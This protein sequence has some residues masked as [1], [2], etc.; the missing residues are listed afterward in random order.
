MAAH[1]Q[2]CSLARRKASRHSPPQ[3]LK[4]LHLQAATYLRS[5][6]TTRSVSAH[7][8]PPPLGPHRAHMT[9]MTCCS[10]V[11]GQQGK[12]RCSSACPSSARVPT[13]GRYPDPRDFRFDAFPDSSAMLP[14]LLFLRA[15]SEFVQQQPAV[16]N[17]VRGRLE[18]EEQAAGGGG[19]GGGRARRPWPCRVLWMRLVQRQQKKQQEQECRRRQGRKL[20]PPGACCAT[21]GA[22]AKMPR[23]RTGVVYARLRYVTFV[24]WDTV[25]RNT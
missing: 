17:L 16:T 3:R 9:E 4:L 12:A 7:W 25:V 10:L 19:A 13:V 24:W 21:M 5:A 8:P 18:P 23:P 20:S 11:L 22:R 2:T 6:R 1:A 14:E 15:F